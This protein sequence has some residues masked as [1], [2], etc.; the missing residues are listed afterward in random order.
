MA[1]SYGNLWREVVSWE[2]LVTAYHKCRRRKRYKREAVRFHFT[3]E[4]NLLHLQR[5][6]VNGSYC[7]GEYHHYY[8]YDPKKRKISAAP[9]LD[10]VV[11]HAV[12]NVLEPIFER[13][14]IF[15][16]YACRRGKGTHRA[17]D[18]AQVY[19]RRHRFVLKSD[20]VKFF[21]NVDHQLLLEQLSR[22]IRDRPLM[23]LIAI[24]LKSGEGVLQDEAT[25]DVFPGDDLF[26]C[27]RPKGLPIGNLTSQFLANV[28]LD[29]VD[30]F[31]KEELRVPGY[32]RYADDLALFGDSKDQVWDWHQ[33]L[34][35]RLAD[36]RL[37]LH[38]D[39]TQLRPTRAGINFLGFVLRPEG[40]RLQQR[41]IRRFSRRCRQMKRKFR[42]G[43]VSAPA[44]RRS[45]K[46]WL[47]HASNANSRGI[48]REL[49]KRLVLTRGRTQG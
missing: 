1:H 42:E 24:I 20:I 22:T 16:S 46:A 4:S 31:I 14:F 10:R 2:N 29:P 33:R 38:R 8:I 12:V 18:R 44:I 48:R 25:R 41:T 37:R 17:L 30:H 3:W 32:V 27:L 21:P 47:A 43:S 11:H 23:D 49:W 15:D 34:K 19:L 36:L 26:S 28:L 40:R 5:L 9:F 7:P 35:A 13:R 45:L 6:L 39:K